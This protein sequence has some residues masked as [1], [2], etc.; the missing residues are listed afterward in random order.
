MDIHILWYAF[1]THAWLELLLY[2]VPIWWRMKAAR[3]FYA[4]TLTVSLGF[5]TGALLLSDFNFIMVLVAFFGAYRLVNLLRI[6]E[7]RSHVLRQRRATAR[8]GVVL[9]GCQG[10][11]IGLSWIVSQISIPHNTWLY[12]LVGAQLF[13]A[14]TLLISTQ[15]RLRHTTLRAT[16]EAYAMSELPTVTV[17]I[18]ARNETES[19][20][21]CLQSLVENTYPKLEI[22]V[23]DD[24]SQ[25]RKTP[26][27][28]RGFAHAGVRFLKGEVPAENWL[29]KNQAYDKLAQEASG[30]VIVFCGVDT[31]F[32][33][34]TINQLVMELLTRKKRMLSVV[35]F[36]KHIPKPVQSFVQA[37]RYLWEFTPPRRLFNRPPVMSSCWIIYRKDLVKLG[38]F[39]AVSRMILPEAYFA[40]QH[41][42]NDEYS[43]L[44]GSPD[45]GL[46]SAKGP[47]EQRLTAVR[48]RYPQLHR[49]P[50][51]VAILTLLE[52]LLL[53]A[54][55]ALVMFAGLGMA[56]IMAGV[57]ALIA[58]ACLVAAHYMVATQT[59]L[60]SRSTAIWSMP[61][62]IMSDIG[63]MHVSMQQYEFSEVMWKG[64]NVC[65]PVMHVIPNLPKA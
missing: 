11:L 13:I 30:E 59:H 31:R 21:Q 28:I 37:A 50:E 7:N 40:R 10:L 39:K 19:L 25:T 38:G 27:I 43:F 20:E 29:A 32:E 17:A 18:P 5:L 55:F 47:I 15:R 2:I 64:R 53:L 33:S 42:A 61:A 22:L 58:A 23:L 54:P 49:R 16:K 8:T 36:R 60:Q 45:L 62:V 24:C 46:F 52:V 48:T 63:L 1:L 14:I 57:M 41:L 4:S 65:V 3:R 12:A 51:N 44:R 35:P 6:V 9:L 26:E 34:N 56:P